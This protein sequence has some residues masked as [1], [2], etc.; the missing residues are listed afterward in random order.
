[1]R[2]FQWIPHRAELPGL[3]LATALG[4]ASLAAV[5]ALPRSPY[6]SDVLIALTLGAF[7]LNT[8]L[9]RL[10]RLELPGGDREPD[11]Y[12]PGLRFCGK[13]VLRLGII[14]MGL[15]VQTS[16]FGGAE[17]E[18][19]GA[20][21]LVALPSA[22]FV[23][24]TLGAILGVRRPLTD[25]LAGGTMICGAS[26]VNAIAP[27]SRAHRE[28]QGVAIGVMFL[29]S[30]VALV[31]FRP[32]ALAIGLD[33]S[34][35]GIWSGL[36]VT[37]LSSAIAVG[38]QMGGTGGVM[39]TAAK[40]AR[41]VMLAPTLVAFSL[42]RSRGGPKE[43]ESG[44]FEH[45]PR[46]VLGYVALAVARTLGDRAFA[47]APAWSTLL[48]ADRFLVDLTMSTVSASIGLHLAFRTLL[49]SGA[50]AVAVGGG[51][52]LTIAGL[53]LAMITLASRGAMP[54]AALVGAGGLVTSALA[55]RLATSR[56][57]ESDALRERF[58]R[59][60]P[61]AL[62]EA[63]KVLDALESDGALDDAALRKMIHQLYPAIGE[64]IPVRKSP[65]PHGEGCRWITYWE[66]T[67]GW[68]LVALCRQPGSVTPIHAHPHRLL[69]KAIEGMLEELTFEDRGAGAYALTSRRVLGHN[70]L[71]ETPGL[72]ALHLV[73]AVGDREAIDLQL[74]GPECGQPGVRLSTSIDP[75]ALAVGETFS[76]EV[77]TDDRPGH[78]GEGAACGR[79]PAEAGGDGS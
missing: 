79:P 32:I 42:L 68:A 7:L 5:H 73:R 17:L 10:I 71:V 75:L 48:A 38:A 31:C 15:K 41:V 64:L 74:R 40:S 65:L 29:F 36:A 57:Q 46:F 23:A 70:E 67:S 13:W 22:F 77:E 4:G 61:L 28:E 78:G 3:A 49:A 25:L 52:A 66:G 35:A 63:T 11:A 58:E 51:A 62:A 60:A 50:R 14:A 55:Y 47:G 30:V 69:G 19:I 6:V 20:V 43:V 24:H 34:F 9:R 72:A 1:M 8:P 53:T 26:A 76:A 59:G 45:L 56:H 37:D 39:A 44:F 27:I 54:A 18:L 12:A 2:R 33:S 21:G 16:S